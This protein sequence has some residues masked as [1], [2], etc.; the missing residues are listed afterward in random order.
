MAAPGTKPKPHSSHPVTMPVVQHPKPMAPPM[1]PHELAGLVERAREG[2]VAAFERLIAS[3]Q[4]KV[5]T[6]AFA[7]TGSP[8]VAQDLAQD[9]LVKVYKSLGSFRFQSAFST[10]LYSIVK[11]TYLDAVKSRAGRER[12]LEEPLTERDVAD[13]HEAATAEERLLAKESR[14]TVLR[15]LRQVPV[16]YRTVVALADVQGLGYE[17]IA[18]ALGVPVGTVKSR[19]KRGRD[20]LKDALY[21]QRM[22]EEP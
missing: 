2:D 15:A 8:D 9:A 19:L 3:Y 12:A 6:F 1:P 13:L 20:A 5:Y 4:P 17:E 18:G 16:A 10:W 7:F 22:Q 11:N 21:R 14:R